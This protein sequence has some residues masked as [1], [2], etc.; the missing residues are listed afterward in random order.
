MSTRSTE[1]IYVIE[2]IGYI[3]RFTCNFYTYC[4]PIIDFYFSFYFS[5]SIQNVR[6]ISF[7]KKYNLVF[8][9]MYFLVTLHLQI[10]NER[11]VYKQMTLQN[12]LMAHLK[13]YGAFT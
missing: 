13:K 7:P 6:N 5:F 2:G 11:K 3:Y 4:R 1:L 12:W 9:S 8:M 10:C